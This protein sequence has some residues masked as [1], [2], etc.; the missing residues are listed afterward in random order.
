[1]NEISKVLGN[2]GEMAAESC[3]QIREQFSYKVSGFY[4][5][6]NECGKDPFRVFCDYSI[7]KGTYYAFLGPLKEGETLHG[8]TKI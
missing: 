6:K 7:F 8:V 1:M 2:S 4:W 5:V 3:A